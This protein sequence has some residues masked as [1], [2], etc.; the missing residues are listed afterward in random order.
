MAPP[1]NKKTVPSTM[2]S[3]T[4]PFKANE[5]YQRQSLLWVFGFDLLDIPSL[6][7]SQGDYTTIPH[8]NKAAA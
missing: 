4:A 1:V 8:E 2:L 6:R 5:A 3:A 7:I